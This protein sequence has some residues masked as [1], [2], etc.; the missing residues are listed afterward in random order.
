MSSCFCCAGLAK[1][2]RENKTA[3]GPDTTLTGSEASLPLPMPSTS[4][5]AVPVV[6]DGKTDLKA[7]LKAAVTQ[8]SV[9][10]I[11]ELA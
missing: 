5:N 10:T 11:R 8:P 1:G 2:S 7:E 4:T 6:E 3:V 9:K